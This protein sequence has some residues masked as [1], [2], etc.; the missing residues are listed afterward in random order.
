MPAHRP[1]PTLRHQPVVMEQE[2]STT[3]VKDLEHPPISL[4]TARVPFQ[5]ISDTDHRGNRKLVPPNVS[6]THA[7]LLTPTASSP[8]SLKIRMKTNPIASVDKHTDSLS[9]QNTPGPTE[10]CLPALTSTP[11]SHEKSLPLLSSDSDK[12]GFS[13]PST[14]STSRS[15]ENCLSSTASESLPN[16]KLLP[17]LPPSLHSNDN[18]LPSLWNSSRLNEVP[19]FGI[20]SPFTSIKFGTASLP[21]TP[22]CTERHLGAQTLPHAQNSC[23]PQDNPLR[24][25]SQAA[26]QHAPLRDTPQHIVSKVQEQVTSP[27]HMSNGSLPQRMPSHQSPHNVA[28]A[29]TRAAFQPVLS[30]VS[31]QPAGSIASPRFSA[32]GYVPSQHHAKFLASHVASATKSSVQPSLAACRKPTKDPLEISAKG[33]RI[34]KSKLPY[35][36]RKPAHGKRRN[37]TEQERKL[38]RDAVQKFG[39][40]NWQEVVKHMRSHGYVRSVKQA[41][42]RYRNHESPKLLPTNKWSAEEDA[43]ILERY[44]LMPKQW[45]NICKDPRLS[46]R[47]P[48]HLRNR[49]NSKL[50]T[51]VNHKSGA[52]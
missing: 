18:C 10:K 33:S 26:Q 43:A 9:P 1:L 13:L 14:W 42:E 21:P 20:R 49:F 37:W 29:S 23:P 7:H 45:S 19:R 34:E 15:H 46:R 40:S 8:E 35:K 25:L 12:Q 47:S 30:H 36:K 38:L 24:I 5:P 11:R 51:R 31:G 44:P 41:R 39:E 48:V 3:G 32:S 27:R 16:P 6:Q 2:S 50:H 52:P 22:T 4:A 28:Q 17:S